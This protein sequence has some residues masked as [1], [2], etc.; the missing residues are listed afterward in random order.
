VDLQELDGGFMTEEIPRHAWILAQVLADI[1]RMP[2]F[3]VI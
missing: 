3:H 2:L 1:G